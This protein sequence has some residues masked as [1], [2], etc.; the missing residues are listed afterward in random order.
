[1]KTKDECDTV[2]LC[3]WSNQI[4]QMSPDVKENDFE[5]KPLEL[6]NTMTHV[7]LLSWC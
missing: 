1:M 7:Y 4:K 2:S 6:K 3:D 5:S